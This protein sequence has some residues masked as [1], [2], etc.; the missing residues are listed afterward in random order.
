MTVYNIYKNN[1]KI[2]GPNAVAFVLRVFV[3]NIALEPIQY[4]KAIINGDSHIYKTS[5]KGSF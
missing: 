2:I 5:S 3:K 4:V 1:R